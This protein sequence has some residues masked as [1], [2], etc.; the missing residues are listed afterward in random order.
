MFQIY[1][2]Q[3]LK[4]LSFTFF[5]FTSAF[6]YPQQKFPLENHTEDLYIYT[7][8]NGMQ[9][10]VK[11]TPETPQVYVNLTFRA[12]YENQTPY[13]SGFFELYKN[14][15][16]NE[17]PGER[18]SVL[19]LFNTKGECSSCRTS[20]SA[21]V[22]PDF[23][24]EY[25]ESLAQRLKSFSFSDKTILN[26]Y[27]L[28]KKEIL[29]YS[30][31]ESSFINCAVNSKVYADAPW[32]T[33]T[34]VSPSLFSGYSEG[35]LRTI[36][37][38]LQARFFS[39]RNCALFITG[40][41]KP[42]DVYTSCMNVFSE[43]FTPF[44]L[45]SFAK[46]TVQSDA[47]QPSTSASG[48]K[49][50]VIASKKIS[51]EFNQIAVEYDSFSPA[52]TDI[53]KTS[54]KNGNK[55][56]YEKIVSSPALSLPSEEYAEVT[57][58]RTETGTRLIFQ[59]M[60]SSGA[61]S[62]KEQAE[63]YLKGIK[64]SLSLER[65]DFISAQKL[66]VK[67][68][69]KEFS[70][71]SSFMELLSQFWSYK[72]FYDEYDFYTS[73]L[74]FKTQPILESHSELKAKTESETPFVF[75]I[76]NEDIYEKN[77][78]ELEEYGFILL[79]EKT[80]TWYSDELYKNITA[81]DLK[82]KLSPQELKLSEITGKTDSTPE[83]RFYFFTSGTITA[84]TL[85][86]GIPVAVKEDK[87]SHTTSVSIAVLE[88]ELSSPENQ[89]ELTAVTIAASAINIR[90]AFE[91][92]F[93]SG[94]LN[95]IPQIDSDTEE[96]VS[97]FNIE[98]NPDDI[99][100]VLE[101]VSDTIIFGEIK[102]VAADEAANFRKYIMRKN[103]LS[104]KFQ[105]ENIALKKVFSKT[106]YEKLFDEKAEILKET[107]LHSIREA[108]SRLMNAG[109]YSIT[110]SGAKDAEKVL[111]A[112][113]K[114][115][116]VLKE[117][118]LRKPLPSVNPALPEKDLR[119]ELFHTFTTDRPAEEAPKESPVLIPTSD[120]YDPALFVF[121]SPKDKS[122][123]EVFNA[124]LYN[125][126]ARIQKKVKQGEIISEKKARNFFP[127]ALITCENLF[128]LSDF[129]NAYSQARKEL[130][131]E[132]KNSDEFALKKIKSRWIMKNFSFDSTEKETARAI[133]YGLLKGKS[134]S[135]L[136]SYLFV[137]NASFE[138]MLQIMEECFPEKPFTAYSSDLKQ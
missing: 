22:T 113:E 64:E 99:D 50:F 76:L 136:D 88:G 74:D 1:K 115:F 51:Q 32:K 28:L 93:N 129:K 84:G 101:I 43:V 66:V 107:T 124:L 48:G 59:S 14:I 26:E 133:H 41:I 100:E 86:N 92:K 39:T 137:Q 60:F 27:E 63:V 5:I 10:F 69:K 45:T 37:T 58:S 128:R 31:T 95:E 126:S 30:Q 18:D 24:D 105:L 132:L 17:L 135:Y 79:T 40:N 55:I 16:L 122:Q 98:C 97:F 117:E 119:T 87:N 127:A 19:S 61:A 106:E 82:K 42:Q 120:F 57:S 15:F 13:T 4:I 53:I 25:L 116:S 91:E 138:D 47:A 44:P 121:S 134:E 72:S 2:T 110:I 131:E 56:Y 118:T 7:L 62:P 3:L 83:E 81:S 11:Y 75:L 67:N 54:I 65:S 20:F 6:L 52:E 111:A 23:F 29:E 114:N 102:P 130:S 96:C 108:Y 68:N 109:L 80:S 46:D 21:A 112:C 85:S 36:L 35:E 78:A 125:L 73:F 77:R 71:N 9:A 70:K 94:M 8:A 89:R 103:K 38:E 123:T 49:K 90:S 12:G 34:G 104:L 33:D